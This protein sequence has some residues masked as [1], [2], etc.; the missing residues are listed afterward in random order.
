MACR[1]NEPHLG[2]N[3]EAIL[4][5]SYPSFRVIIVTDTMD[6][7][8]YSVANSMIKRHPAKDARLCI[9]DAYPN[10]AGKVAALL[11]GLERDEWA[12]E[13]YA[14]VDSDALTTT[15]WLRDMMDP[16]RD[17]S[18]GAT[19]GFRW[20]V[21]D[22]DGFWPQVESAWNASGTNVMFS[23]KYN[24]PW[25]G[26][27]AILKETMNATGLR[28]VWQTA[29]SDDLSLNRALRDHNYRIEFLPQCT[30]ITRSQTTARDFLKW[31][32]RQVAITRAFNRELWVYGLVAY[33]F[34]TLLSVLAIASI[35]AGITLSQVWLLPAA[36]LLT[37]EILGVFRS[38]GRVKSFK[39]ALPE[40]AQDL[41]GGR[42][43]HSIA[44]L[45]VPWIMTYCIIRSAGTDEIEWRGRKYKLNGKRTLAST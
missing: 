6:D 10:A 1:G 40:F 7:P 30:V 15:T 14:F 23:G 8:A 5:Q 2:E 27:M 28:A 17:R 25:G 32:C 34:F 11:T 3:I 45:I 36:L 19:T 12:S 4:N 9:A 20:Y 13:G 33:G 43:G 21:P 22:K 18:I 35:I 29:V 24:F 42:L 37:P 31:A 44:S 38:N 26:A 39:R 41:E 16:L